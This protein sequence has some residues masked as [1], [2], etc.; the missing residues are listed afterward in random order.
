M[1]AALLAACGLPSA[2]TP[3]PVLVEPTVRPTAAASAPTA[4]AAAGS[5][6][7]FHNGVLLTMDESQP[8]ASA[9]HIQGETIASVGSD[10]SVLAEVGPQTL[11]VDLGGRTLMPG[12]VDAHSHYFGRKDFFPTADEAQDAALAQGITTTAEFYVEE[13]ML[14]ELQALEASGGL[15]LRLS[16]Y[17]SWNTGCGDQL[18]GWYLDHPA[19]RTPGKKLWIN[20]VKIFTDGGSCNV[21]AVSFE[22]PGGYGHGDPYFSVTEL[23]SVIREL[24]GAGYQLA[25]H[26]IGDRALDVVLQAYTDVLHGVNPRHHRIEHNAVLRPDQLPLYT[27]AGAVATLLAPFQTCASLGDP[28]R[29]RYLMPESYKTWEWP[30]RDLLDANPNVHFAW[31]ADMP[32]FTT[33]VFQ[34]LYGFVTRNQVAEDGTICQAP[35]WLARNALTVDEALRLMTSGAAYALQREAEVG[36][37]TA[38]KFADVIILSENPQAIPSTE[39]KGLKVLMTMVGGTVEYCAERMEALCPSTAAAAP[40]AQQGPSIPFRDDFEGA[41]DPGWSWYQGEAPGWTLSN[42]PGWL[43]LNL[44]TGSFFGDVPPANLLIRPAPLGDFDLKAWLRFSPVRNFELAGL[45]VVFDEASVLQFGRGF[46]EVPSAGAGCIGDGLYFDS[47]QNGSPVGGNFATQSLLGV[48]YLLRLQRQGNTYDAAYSTDGSSW[49][50]LGIHTVDRPPVSMGLIA[51]Q[52]ETPGNF[53]DFDY[54][55][56][57][58]GP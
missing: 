33:D 24:D 16:A 53:A 10:A 12:F 23:E 31:H 50:P 13:A 39:L 40:T 54:V 36:S 46:C 57:T 5:D 38:G 47:I 2:N 52:A 4:Q 51:A 41:L 32:I 6:L 27:Q 25:I 17:L 37:L 34:H 9:I 11:V 26:A 18:G 15:R 29:F 35:D 44:S 56:L 58:A 8:S 45:V 28:S 42:M 7:I 20:G 49:V 1:G 22:Y 43:R 55:E 48:D 30:W 14:D 21:P 19:V 3:A